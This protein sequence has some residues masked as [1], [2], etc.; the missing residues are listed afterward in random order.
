MSETASCRPFLAKYCE[1]LGLDVGYGGSAI[2]PSALTFDTDPPYTNVGSDK[3]ILK[4]SC[5]N[6]GM[7]CDE[8]LDYIYSSHLLEDF[9]FGDLVNV[10][11]EWRRVLKV[12]GLLVTNCPDQQQ[13]LAHIAVTGQGNNLA[14]KE[15]DFSLQNFK[16]R[17]LSHTGSW[18]IVYEKPDALPYSWYLV[19]RKI[20]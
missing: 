4:G 20:G 13:F 18:E 14:H 16:D 19:T 17:V 7:F 3:Q 11:K 2:V 15:Q 6:L 5:T 10:I 1:G 9:S 12:G 8:S